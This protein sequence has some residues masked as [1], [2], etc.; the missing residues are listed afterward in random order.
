MEDLDIDGKKIL[1]WIL[2][3]CNGEALTGLIWVM[4]IC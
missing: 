4:I 3:N 1:K 2:E